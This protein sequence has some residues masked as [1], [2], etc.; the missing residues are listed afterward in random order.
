MNPAFNREFWAALDALISTHAWV[1]D[2]PAGTSHPRFPDIVYPYDYGYLEGTTAA[3]G[4]GVD[5]WV[6]SEV[7]KSLTGVVMTVDL[8]KKDTELKLLIGCTLEEMQRIEV[9]HNGASQSGVLIVRDD[10]G[11]M[12]R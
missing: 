6:G 9:H 2:R 12:S 1:I 7:P 10:D 3:D 11:P 5:L 8:F 4:G